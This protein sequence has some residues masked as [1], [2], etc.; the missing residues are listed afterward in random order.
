MIRLLKYYIKD[1]PAFMFIIE[2][3]LFGDCIECPVTAE[4]IGQ[5]M[6]GN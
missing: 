5:M 6:G 3:P 1:E 4:E 2:H